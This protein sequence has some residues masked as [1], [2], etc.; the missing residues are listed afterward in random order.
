[1]NEKIYCLLSDNTISIIDQMEISKYIA[2]HKVEYLLIP[3]GIYSD[4][5][6]LVTPNKL[7]FD[8]KKIGIEYK[9]CLQEFGEEDAIYEDIYE[10][11]TAI[12]LKKSGIVA[13]YRMIHSIYNINGVNSILNSES[14]EEYSA[15]VFDYFKVH[16]K[17][18]DRIISQ[19]SRDVSMVEASPYSCTYVDMN[20]KAPYIL[21]CIDHAMKR[22]TTKGESIIP[23]LSSKQFICIDV[24]RHE[25]AETD[26]IK[27]LLKNSDKSNLYDDNILIS[28]PGIIFNS[29]MFL[30]PNDVRILNEFEHYSFGYV[31]IHCTKMDFDDSDIMASASLQELYDNKLFDIAGTFMDSSIGL[32]ELSSV[33]EILN[34]F[35]YIFKTLQ[36]LNDKIFGICDRLIIYVSYSA[37]KPKYKNK[38]FIY[39]ITNEDV[40]DDCNRDFFS[41]FINDAKYYLESTPKRKKNNNENYEGWFF[42]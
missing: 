7:P 35:K 22:D 39:A 20:S 29:M 13:L 33:A 3:V 5:Y 4:E 27:K 37:C 36:I 2:K 19:D 9:L 23:S 6:C 25:W 10:N 21:F 34:H 30:T 1:M 24:V 14:W 15:F 42:E 26:S 32:Y 38:D 31:M 28:I 16:V 12:K 18:G 17:I 8:V 11:S 41:E 40:A